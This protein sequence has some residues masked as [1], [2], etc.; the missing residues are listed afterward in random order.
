[1]QQ[2]C[3]NAPPHVPPPHRQRVEDV[4]LRVEHQVDDR[5]GTLVERRHDELVSAVTLAAPVALSARAGGAAPPAVNVPISEL[6]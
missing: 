2:M 6:V 3:H 1:M 4:P 5:V